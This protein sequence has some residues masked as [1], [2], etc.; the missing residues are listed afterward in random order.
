MGFTQLKYNTEQRAIQKALESVDRPGDFCV[1]S[2]LVSPMPR[3]RVE[4]VGTVAFP[5][6]EAQIRALIGVAERAPY[7]K[8]PETVLDTSVRD[9]WQIDS[10]AFDL[11][12]QGWADSFEQIMRDVADGLGCAFERLE[13]KPYKLLVYEPGGF[14]TPHRDTEKETGMVGTLVI[15]LPTEGAG[16]ELVVRHADR[17]SIIDM[18]V[19]DPSALAY[20]AFFADC[21]HE[22]L[23]VREGHRIA[24][25]FNLIL[26]GTD[27]SKLGRSPDF[28]EQAE[29]IAQSLREWSRTAEDGAKIVWV[30]DHDYSIAGLSFS[31]LKGIDAAVAGTLREASE[32]AGCSLHAAILHI[33]EY[34]SAD[35]DSGG[36]GGWYDDDDVGDLDMGAVEDWDCAL[37]EW[38]AVDDSKP[39]FGRIPL[40]DMEM[41]PDQ[42]LADAYPDEKLVEEASGNAGVGVEHVYRMAALVVWPQDKAIQT[43]ATGSI[44]SA[45][46][47]VESRLEATVAKGIPPTGTKALGEALVKAWHVERASGWRID[48]SKEAIGRMI[49][50]LVKISDPDLA[51]DFLVTSGIR[52]YSGGENRELVAAAGLIGAHAMDRYLT[53]FLPVNVPRHPNEV[54]NLLWVLQQTYCDTGSGDWCRVLARST[55]LALAA[56]PHALNPPIDDNQP[57]YRPQPKSLDGQAVCDLFSLTQHLELESDADAAVRLISEHPSLATPDRTVPQALVKMLERNRSLAGCRAYEALWLQATAFLLQRSGAVPQVPRD[58]FIEAPLGCDCRGCVQLKAFCSDAAATETKIAVARPERQHLRDQIKRLLLDIDYETE[59]RGRPYR[60]VC[61][62]NRASYQRRL[63][64]YGEDVQQMKVL[65]GCRPPSW[66]RVDHSPELERLRT[67]AALTS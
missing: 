6:L 23:P 11:G 46:A 22:T 51:T 27:A 37:E 19:D 60:L 16:G 24:L 4:H 54:F 41:L 39:D 63:A 35:Y 50:V 9:C 48:P 66:L 14:F 34:G 65:I 61:T 64:E 59:R 13:A 10:S 29:A 7:G 26:S 44:A 53:E 2:R 12:G 62:K 52:T 21:A 58:W 49:A 5:V 45:I 25:V 15:S 47:H 33:T 40:R 55:G 20:A 17:E 32:N 18:C 3:L 38:V 28:T 43:L 36:Y 30:L 8:G 42:A 67:A 57:W 56:L 1:H 31:A